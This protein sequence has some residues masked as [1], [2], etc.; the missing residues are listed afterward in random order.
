MNPV[1]RPSEPTLGA[2]ITNVD[3]NDDARHSI[4]DAFHAHAVLVFPDQHPS[5]DAQVAFGARFG[6]IEIL[7]ENAKAVEF[8]NRKPDG[9]MLEP[10]KFRFKTLRGNEGWHMD[11]SYVPLAAKA[12]L[13]SAM[14]VPPNG[15][16]TEFADT[17][18]AYDALDDATQE[19]I[20][21][22][23]AYHSL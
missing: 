13:L 8:T 23:S 15:G 12:G 20:E 4:E 3:L 2:V 6:E 7:R 16:E 22:L 5:A 11:S 18:A 19:R 17:R 14:E 21:D 9:T 10:E 1:I